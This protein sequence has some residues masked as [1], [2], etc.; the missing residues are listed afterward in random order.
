MVIWSGWGVLAVLFA[1]VGAIGGIGLVDAAGGL[2]LGLPEDSGFALGLLVAAVVNWFVGTR[3]NRS[4]GRELI[5]ANTGE[6]VI[7]RRQHTL[8]WVP[9]QY[10]SVV[11]AVFAVLAVTSSHAP[12]KPVPAVTQQPS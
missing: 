1:V 7:L 2:G 5:D 11:M 10:W 3:L 6:R 8:F 12:Q 9:M 4:L